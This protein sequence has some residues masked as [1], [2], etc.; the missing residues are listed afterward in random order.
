MADENNNETPQKISKSERTNAK[1]LEN[2]HTAIAIVTSIGAGYKPTNV[3]IEK[4]DLLDF[5]QNFEDMTQS[6]LT[7]TADEQNKVDAQISAFKPVSSRVSL[8][9]KSARAQGLDPLFIEGLQATVY[10]LRGVRLG[11]NTPDESPAGGDDDDAAGGGSSS[12]SR[13]SYAGILENLL[14]FSTQLASN[15]AHNPN[16]AEY[17]SPAISTWVNNLSAVHDTA[18]ESKVATRAKRAER[19]RYVYNDTDGLIP[20]MNALK[21]YLGY[22][23]DK[24]DPRLK[25]MKSLKFTNNTK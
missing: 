7:A 12:V 1:N 21:N 14:M 20:R 4:D 11:K 13:R 16:E 25:Q 6:I 23:L 18:L 17:K 8:I 19:N 2:L 15:A 22:I 5:E 10:R 24:S 9:M 3:L